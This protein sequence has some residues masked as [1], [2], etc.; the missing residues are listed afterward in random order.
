[1]T[2]QF[3]E[4]AQFNLNSDLIPLNALSTKAE[5]EV[6][7]KTMATLK[8]APVAI[9]AEGTGTFA[10][11]AGTKHVTIHSTNAD[12]FFTV[13]A[14]TATDTTDAGITAGTYDITGSGVVELS[15]NSS[16]IT[17]ISVYCSA[18]STT[19]VYFK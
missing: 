6:N 12:A 10:V 13:Y 17:N 15:I 16:D 18:A 4:A 19:F 1:M 5:I 3:A 8:P 7:N 11:P 14:Q 2:K 9:A